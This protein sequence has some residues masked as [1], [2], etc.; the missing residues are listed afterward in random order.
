MKTHLTADLRPYQCAKCSGGFLTRFQLDKHTFIRHTTN[1][2]QVKMRTNTNMES[3]TDHTTTAEAPKG[4]PDILSY[5]LL[6][7]I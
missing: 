3:L 1:R 4:I 5:I 6:S 7:N 2:D